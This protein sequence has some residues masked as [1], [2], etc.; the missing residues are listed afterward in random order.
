MS[1]KIEFEWCIHIYPMRFINNLDVCITYFVH[2]F[3]S[4]FNLIV[5]NTKVDGNEIYQKLPSIEEFLKIYSLKNETT[6]ITPRGHSSMCIKS[7]FSI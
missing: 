5:E 4:L 3:N 1:N 2:N 7:K 6:Y